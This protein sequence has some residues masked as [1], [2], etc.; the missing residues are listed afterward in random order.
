MKDTQMASRNDG[1]KVALIDLDGTVADY[2]GALIE[3]LRKLRSPGESLYKPYIDNLPAWYQARIDMIRRQPGWWENLPII[4]LGFQLV[5]AAIE[6]GFSLNVLTKGPSSHQQEASWTEKL[7]WCRNHIPTA[8]NVTITEDKSLVYGRILVDDYPDYQMDWAK[9]RP[10]G[11]CV[12]P[13]REG[14]EWFTQEAANRLA[15]EAGWDHTPNII[16]YN[17]H[18]LPEVLDAMERAYSRQPKEALSL[19][20]S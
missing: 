7:R 17:G 15:E 13:D 4:P 8:V 16:R 9:H 12:V 20:S 1:E 14:N 6:V 3:E 2:E 18:N 5:E 19:A 10:R 11:L